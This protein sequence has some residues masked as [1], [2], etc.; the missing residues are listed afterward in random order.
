MGPHVLTE[1]HIGRPLEFCRLQAGS[2]I[3]P[4]ATGHVDECPCLL[5][6]NG[7]SEMRPHKTVIGGVLGLLVSSLNSL[8][9]ESKAILRTDKCCER[10]ANGT[11]IE[12]QPPVN[13]FDVMDG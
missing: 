10:R 6:T 11:G 1:I 7:Y 5:N 12:R 4:S 8:K 3:C 2:P 9:T 13:L